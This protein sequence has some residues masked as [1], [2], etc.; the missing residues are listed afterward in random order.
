MAGKL[1]IALPRH[2]RENGSPKADM[3]ALQPHFRIPAFAG[4][5]VGGI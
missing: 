5:T 4:M 1:T 2:S 3:L